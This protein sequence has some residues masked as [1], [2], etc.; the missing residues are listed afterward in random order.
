MIKFEMHVH[1]KGGSRCAKADVDTIVNHYASKGY[2]GLV[3]TNHIDSYNYNN[4]LVGDNHKEKTNYFFSL[5]EDAK[6]KGEKLNLKIFCGIEVRDIDNTE[7]M[8]YGFEPRLLYD[9]KPLFEY[10]QKELFY[11]AEKEKLFMYQT[12]PFRYGVKCGNPKY[13]HG[14]EAFNGHFHHLNNN[15]QAEE[16]CNKY[17]LIKMSGTDYHEPNQP[18]TSYMYIP[19]QINN[20]QALVEYLFKGKTE[21]YGDEE[22]YMNEFMKAQRNIK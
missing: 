1:S 8:L 17:N 16:F 4:T 12:H 11:L 18:L 9:N 14:A 3:I 2:D 13:M 19:S 6:I 22:Y 15:K 20:E 7:Y 10:N 21:Y 5:Y